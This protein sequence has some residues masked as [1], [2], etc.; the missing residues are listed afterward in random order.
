MN[1]KILGFSEKIENIFNNDKFN[2]TFKYKDNLYNA[3]VYF[4]NNKIIELEESNLIS[5]NYSGEYWLEGKRVIFY[6]NLILEDY[7]KYKEHNNYMS[8]SS[9]TIN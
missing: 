8:F 2:V 1:I 7:H 3:I 9:F 6:I 4:Q 5:R